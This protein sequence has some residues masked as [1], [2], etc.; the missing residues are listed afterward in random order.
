[1]KTFLTD[2]IVSN[3]AIVVEITLIDSYHKNAELESVEDIDSL[4]IVSDEVII[5]EPLVISDRTV[6]FVTKAPSG[7]IEFII[8]NYHSKGQIHSKELE[9]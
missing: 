3:G 4:S 8:L 9:V 7:S 1:M 5:L 2:I 6:K